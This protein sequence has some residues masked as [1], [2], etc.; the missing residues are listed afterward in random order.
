MRVAVVAA[1]VAVVLLFGCADKPEAM[2]ASAK[3]YLGKNDRNAAVIQL[4]NALQK[5]P[6]LAE[7][8]FLLG[9]TLLE[10]GDVAAAEKELRRAAELKYPMDSVAPLLARLL[11]ARGEYKQ[12]IDEFAK[13]DLGSADAKAELQTTLGEAYLATGKVEIAKDRF[14]TALVVRPDYAPAQLGAARVTALGGDV[15]GALALVDAAMS[16]SPSLPEG[17]QLKG[18]LLLAQGQPDPAIDAYRKALATR[19]DYLPAHSVRSIRRRSIC[20]PFS[21]S[22]R[23]TSSRRAMRS[24]SSSRRRSTIRPDWCL[25]DGSKTGSGLSRR[26]NRTSP[27]R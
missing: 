17:W 24:R 3:D 14:D 22:R 21:H 8:R 2:V 7:A 9:K 6:D 20:R 19:P 5:N 26:P 15:P 16:K 18:D 11:V 27:R 25:P 12:A 23:T 13:V 1:M 10:T 4:K